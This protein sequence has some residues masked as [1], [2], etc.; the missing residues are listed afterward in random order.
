MR[1]LMIA[2]SLAAISTAAHGQ[3]SVWGAFDGPDGSSGVGVQSADGAQLMLKCDKPGKGEVYAV[4]V[5]REPLVPPTNTRFSMRPIELRFD[6]A[7]PFDDRWRFY[8]QSASAVNQKSE[9]QLDRLIA[10]MADAKSM[11]ARL[12]PE[13]ARWV[14]MDFDVTG[15]RTAIGQVYESCKDD[16]PLG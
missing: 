9:N 13:R 6:D 12:N 2:A 10:G 15:A 4:L 1:C 7:A 3:D 11:R 14:E 16:N 5:S 8:E